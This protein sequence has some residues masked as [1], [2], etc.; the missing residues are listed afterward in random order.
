MVEQTQGALYVGS[1]GN[2]QGSMKFFLLKSARVVRRRQFT[3]L[4]MPTK[5][6][7]QANAIGRRTKQEVYGKDLEFLNRIKEKYEWSH[8]DDLDEML[9]ETPPEPA[10]FPSISLATGE[11]VD[12]RAIQPDIQ[13][14]REF[15]LASEDNQHSVFAEPRGDFDVLPNAR[16][17]GAELEDSP[18]PVDDEHLNEE[19]DAVIEV[20]NQEGVPVEVAGEEPDAETP[21]VDELDVRAPEP[22]EPEALGRGHR[23]RRKPRSFDP[24]ACQDKRYT[25][26]DGGSRRYTPTL[27]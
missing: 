11:Q 18:G 3:P 8:E 25:Y 6:I 4:D 10:D 7:A 17:T 19:L 24:S 21:G 1:T 16:T 15:I 23:V 13:T 26:P 22:A 14:E 20:S 2:V 27:S 9:G 12:S 5:V